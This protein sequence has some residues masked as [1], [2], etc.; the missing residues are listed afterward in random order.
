MSDMKKEIIGTIIVVALVAGGICFAVRTTNSSTAA[1][2]GLEKKLLTLQDEVATL[3]EQVASQNDLIAQLTP[4]VAALTEKTDNLANKKAKAQIAA[5]VIDFDNPAIFEELKEAV[6]AINEDRRAE[7]HRRAREQQAQ[8]M[9]RQ[10]QEQLGRYT[11]ELQLN[12]EQKEE[13]KDI[14]EEGLKKGR[15]AM[16]QMWQNRGGDGNVDWRKQMEELY[17]DN[18]AM[19]KEVLSEEQYQK[20]LKLAEKDDMLRSM[21]RG[22]GRRRHGHRHNDREPR[23]EE[24]V[25]EDE[26]EEVD[27][28]KEEE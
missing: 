15:E 4:Q 18:D 26:P 28:A 25:D 7:W 8:W 6:N 12:Q 5:T 27:E 1:V 3:K 20:Y 24:N 16:A 9:E 22:G 10:L 13:M 23:K 21:I 14:W 11:T 19:I 2:Q 17:D